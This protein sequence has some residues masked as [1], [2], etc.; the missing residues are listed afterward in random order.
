MPPANTTYSQVDGGADAGQQQQPAFFSKL[1]ATI[2]QIAPYVAPIANR[3]AA[4][5]GNSASLQ[6]EY[7]DKEIAMQ[8]RHAELAEQLNQSQLQ[9]Q[10]L[11][12]QLLTKQVANVRSP[13]EVEAMKPPTDVVA[14][15]PEGGGYGHYSRTFNPVTKQYETKP[16]MVGMQVPNPASQ[17]QS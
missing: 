8:Q 6:A 17:A 2:K 10:E 7:K 12:R 14:P 3:L 5:F 11:N 1:G 15:M 4:T 13:E 9:N 16:T